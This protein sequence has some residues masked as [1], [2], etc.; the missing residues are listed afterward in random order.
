MVWAQDGFTDKTIIN[1]LLSLTST[2]AL[3][4]M[5]GHIYSRHRKNLDYNR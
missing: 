3:S 4:L 5:G 1:A 2:I